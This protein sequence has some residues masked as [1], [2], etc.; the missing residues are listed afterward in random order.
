MRL[1]CL[2]LES[3]TRKGPLWIVALILMATVSTSASAAP[4]HLSCKGNVL[5]M[6]AETP[7]PGTASVTIDG[8]WITVEGYP[9]TELLQHGDD[10][11]VWTFVSTQDAVFKRAGKINRITGYAEIEVFT[12][13][14]E[15]RTLIWSFDGVCHKAERLF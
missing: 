2:N 11:D 7:E 13:D 10:D 6:G 14:F 4:L 1:S 3:R 8:K 5:K 12:G 15:T 9:P